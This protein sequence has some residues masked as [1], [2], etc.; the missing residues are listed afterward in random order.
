MKERTVV[1]VRRKVRR[2]ER[3][4]VLCGG[5]AQCRPEDGKQQMWDMR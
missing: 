1:L 3:V 2:R 4:S 5:Q